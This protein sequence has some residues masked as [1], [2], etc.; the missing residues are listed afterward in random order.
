[1]SKLLKLACALALACGMA[2]AQG[3]DGPPPGMPGPGEHMRMAGPMGPMGHMGP[4]GNWWKNSDMVQALG[5]TDQQVQQLQST[6]LERKARLIDEQAAAEKE[7]LKLQGLM[8]QDSPD[9]GAVMAELDELNAAHNK[10]H[11]E[12]VSMSLAFRRI[13]T[14][15]QWKKLSGM[16][17]RMHEHMRQQ[18]AP[19]QP[20]KQ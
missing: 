10:L 8:D 9:E 20:P 3:P 17:P 13:L 15:D 5:L 11:K 6:Y 7:E 14:A 19:Q 1:M 2:W 4:M 12:F 18:P 16:H